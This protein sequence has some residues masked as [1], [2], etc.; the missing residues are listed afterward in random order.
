[1]GEQMFYEYGR[2]GCIYEKSVYEQ[3]LRSFLPLMPGEPNSLVDS[4]HSLLNS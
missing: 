3:Q 2:E 1:M 4:A